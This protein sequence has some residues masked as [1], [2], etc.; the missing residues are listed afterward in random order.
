[1]LRQM[2]SADAVRSSEE[3]VHV[4]EVDFGREIRFR[5]DSLILL[6]KLPS[7]ALP[8]GSALVTGVLSHP[9]LPAP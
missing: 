3:T 9:A 1:M 2:T 7:V 6:T 8:T 4:H 5:F